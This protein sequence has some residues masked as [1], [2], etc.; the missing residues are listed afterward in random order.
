MTQSRNHHS[1]GSEI[2]ES[3]MPSVRMLLLSA[4]CLTVG[5]VDA[6]I[7]TESMTG[8]DYTFEA[9]KERI[10]NGPSALSVLDKI[11]YFVVLALAFEVFNQIA[12]HLGG[13]LTRRRILTTVSSLTVCPPNV[14]AFVVIS[15]AP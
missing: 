4:F 7:Q 9:L 3:F 11:V 13:K 6:S 2:V 12:I 8:G 10:M 1:G 15:I 14:L 5:R